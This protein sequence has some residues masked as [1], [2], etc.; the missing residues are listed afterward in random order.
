VF[1]SSLRSVDINPLRGNSHVGFYYAKL[2]RPFRACPAAAGMRLS[3][4][5]SH[6]YAFYNQRIINN[7]QI[8]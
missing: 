4:L 3:A 1:M 6:K 7:I 8:Y 2:L 5:D